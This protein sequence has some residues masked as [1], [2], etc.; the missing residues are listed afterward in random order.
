MF[1]QLLESI[2][3]R[4]EGSL[5]ALIMGTDGIAVEKVFGE[6]GK[7]ANLDVAAAE[8][9]SLVRNAQRSGNETGLGNL[10]ELVVTLE[11][12]VL[13]MRVLSK[14]YF[15]VLALT[16]EGNLGRGRYELRKAE[17]TLA[18]EFTI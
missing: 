11:N 16:P 4:T 2:L 17:L 9:T 12:C 7:E 13:A 1:K 8:F 5:G 18:S 10:R 15:V 14:D 3:E 6:A